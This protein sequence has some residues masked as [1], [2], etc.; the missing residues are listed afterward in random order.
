MTDETLQSLQEGPI[1]ERSA[2]A[3]GPT[4][5]FPLLFWKRAVEKTLPIAI[6]CQHRGDRDQYELGDLD[7]R[8]WP[9][10]TWYGHITDQQILAMALLYRGLTTPTLL[11]LADAERPALKE[12]CQ[13]LLRTVNGLREDSLSSQRLGALAPWRETVF[14]AQDRLTQRR[15]KVPATKFGKTGKDS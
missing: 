2:G 9:A 5:L 13:S 10:T 12:L 6:D 8:F 4:A 11:A 15:E 7:E 3:T 14:R 1:A